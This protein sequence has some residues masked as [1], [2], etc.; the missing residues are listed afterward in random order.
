MGVKNRLMGINLAI[1]AIGA[2]LQWGCSLVVTGLVASFPS[3][4]MQLDGTIQLL[5]FLGSVASFLMF[6][7]IYRVRCS[8][9]ESSAGI[10]VAALGSIAG[11]ALLISPV[12]LGA[13]PVLQYAIGAAFLTAATGFGLFNLITCFAALDV[14][15]RLEIGRAH[16]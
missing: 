14:V 15:T 2:G 1:L 8:F 9:Y 3:L 10:L 11:W 13:A 5:L 16:V 7:P 12:F 4:A 6:V